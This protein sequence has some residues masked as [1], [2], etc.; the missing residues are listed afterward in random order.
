MIRTVLAAATERLGD[1]VDAEVL[2]LHVLDRSRSWLIAHSDDALTTEQAA[3]YADFVARRERGEPVAYIVGSRGFWSLDLDVTPATLI[4]RPDTE[5]LVELALE[6]IST[7]R[8]TKVLDLGTGTGAIALAIASERKNAQI[9]ATDANT[10]ALM[11]AQRNAL[12][13]SFAHVQF[14]HG[15][16]FAPVVGKRFDVIVSNPPYIE[17][18]DPH[19]GQGDLRF[20]PAPALASGHDGLDDIRRIIASA[21]EHLVA[22][23]W[24]LLEHGW[25]QGG[26]VRDLLL[27][28]GF[29]DVFTAQD[30]ERRDR[31]S[32]GCWRVG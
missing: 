23:G 29:R 8:A 13:H 21:G 14:V 19:L 15:D 27:A 11:V 3:A 2:L 17:S 31:V 5:R 1:R 12:R 32:A 22:D 20:E 30:I 28:A 10:D 16:W 26:R 18:D 4:P 25:N 7:E 9:V 6:R 24:L